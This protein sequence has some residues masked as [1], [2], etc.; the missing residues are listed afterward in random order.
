[1]VNVIG[2]WLHDNSIFTLA[3]YFVAD[4]DEDGTIG[5]QDLA[6]TVNC[7]TRNELKMDEV[8]FICEKV[9]GKISLLKC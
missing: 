1:M 3:L 6:K 2:V 5:R 4:F 8:E 9:R 7:L